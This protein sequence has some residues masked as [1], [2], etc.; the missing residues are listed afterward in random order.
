[1]DPTRLEP[2][3]SLREGLR[4]ERKPMSAH[5]IFSTTILCTAAMMAIPL[6]AA[7]RPKPASTQ[8]E[9]KSI[10][11]STAA[12]VDGK[13]LAPGKYEVL[14]EGNKATFEHDHQT[15]VTASCDWKTMPQSLPTTAW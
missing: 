3:I 2:S 5:K 11:L 12:V 6:F 14:I 13:T 4:K 8:M 1:M 10:D 7:A 9:K 15:V